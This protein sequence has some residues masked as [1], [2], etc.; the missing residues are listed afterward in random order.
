MSIDLSSETAV[1]LTKASAK[2]PGRPHRGTLWR[3]ARIGVGG[4][5]LETVRVGGTFYT[6]EEALSRFFAALGAQPI[7]SRSK[8]ETQVE[9]AR[10]A[11]ATVAD[12]KSHIAAERELDA[13]GV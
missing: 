6:T 9:P 10:A 4:I 7:Q 2:I 8:S 1:K 11:H 13:L 5:V 3:W 12:R